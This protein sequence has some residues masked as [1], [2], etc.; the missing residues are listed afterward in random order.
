MYRNRSVDV[1]QFAMVPKA[2]IPR[3]AFNIQNLERVPTDFYY[4]Y[5]HH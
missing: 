1:H 4:P 5:A 3:S 2:D